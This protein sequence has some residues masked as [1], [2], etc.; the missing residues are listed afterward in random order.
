M[1]KVERAK[2]GWKKSKHPQRNTLPGQQRCALDKPFRH[3]QCPP[4]FQPVSEETCCVPESLCQIKPERKQREFPPDSLEMCRQVI[5]EGVSSSQG[6][7]LRHHLRSREE[8]PPMVA[9]L[10]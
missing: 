1:V 10:T 9:Q 6:L 5:R 8:R 4:D 3:L 2:E 7:G